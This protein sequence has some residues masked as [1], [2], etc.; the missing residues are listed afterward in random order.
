MPGDESVTH[1]LNQLRAG[2]QAAAQPLWERYFASL[3]RLARRR[4][5]GARRG[6]AD[7]E[8]VALSAFDS[9]CRAAG[10]NRFPGLADRDDLWRL[11]VTI[12]ERKAIDLVRRENRAS[13]G[14]GRVVG[15]SELPGGAEPG[16][17]GGLGRL[18]GREPTPEFAALVAEECQR[19]LSA[20]D[21][22]TLRDLA[23]LKLEGHSN[24][25]IA[26]RLGCAVRSVE[27]KLALIRELWQGEIEP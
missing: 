21:D 4:L 14:G 23:V 7:E 17:S 16:S 10:E 2:D 24:A 18:P 22:D 15:E 6:A 20:L 13:R 3:V 12:T 27:R 25:E 1:W 5:T 8:D 26:A 9:F 19:L 11:L